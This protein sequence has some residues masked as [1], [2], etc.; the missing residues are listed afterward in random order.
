MELKQKYLEAG[1]TFCPFCQSEKGIVG[2]PFEATGGAA[3]Q[4]VH[5]ELCGKTW[6]DHYKLFDVVQND[7]GPRGD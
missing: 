1:G 2:G 4:E 3:F 7:G 5:C 6:W